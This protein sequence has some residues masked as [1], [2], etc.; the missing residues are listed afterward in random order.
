MERSRVFKPTAVAAMLVAVAITFFFSG[1]TLRNNVALAASP[2]ATSSPPP[3]GDPVGFSLAGEFQANISKTRGA[4]GDPCDTSGTCKFAVDFEGAIA[5]SPARAVKV[6][7]TGYAR[8]HPFQQMMMT[9]TVYPKHCSVSPRSCP[10]L[11]NT[12][13][14]D[15][16]L[17]YP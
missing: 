4:S 2:V 5:S 17:G 7:K 15:G 8:C 9:I 14:V 16:S 1:Y 13:P 3:D 10:P 11:V 12:M 6:C